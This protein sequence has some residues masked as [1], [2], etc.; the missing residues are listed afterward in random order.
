MAAET[1]KTNPPERRLT[2][3]V[4]VPQIPFVHGGAEEH[5]ASLC[6]ELRARGH[7]AE[8]ISLPYKWYPRKRLI[9]NIEMWE[10]LDL[11]ESD[12]Q[13]IDLAIATKF[14]S[15]FVRHERNVLWLIHQ[16]RQLYDLYGTSFSDFNPSSLRDRNFRRRF[17]AR[18]TEAL[19][20]Y[21]RR[22]TNS[23]NTRDRMLK[24][25]GLDAEPLYHPP[26][27]AGRL[28]V[29]EY[30][31]FVLSV[32]RLSPLKRIEGLIHAVAAART[33]VR[34][35]IAGTGPEEDRLK[36]LAHGLGIGGRV[37]FAGFVDDDRLIELYGRCL[38]VFF[39]PV[40]EDYGYITLEAFLAAKP[41]ITC[42]DS[43]GT[44]EFVVHEKNGFVL[45][46]E[47]WTA[48]GA[49][50]DRLYEDRELCRTFGENGHR[51]V[52]GITW[53]HVIDRLLEGAV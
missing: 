40:D 30:G 46:P 41:V 22:F 26:K 14:P 28:R 33:P 43:G 47:D 15:Y 23:V 7:R 24:F 8:I 39:A 17:I 1:E 52:E 5:T 48:A 16:Y 35:V 25:N 4:C 19:A 2:I 13:K 20:R 36:D 42:S 31:D 53:D 34:A 27:L 18:D 32:G 51:A 38:G 11:S 12:G 9:Q 29:M 21:S 49:C 44:M 45:P 10:S 6:R 3:A 37:D 50:L